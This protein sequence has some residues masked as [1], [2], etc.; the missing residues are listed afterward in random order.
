MAVAIGSRSGGGVDER[1]RWRCVV[2]SDGL[3]ESL[4]KRVIDLSLVVRV[5]LV[6]FSI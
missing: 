3:F 1:Q 2:E 5:S 4:E 6:V